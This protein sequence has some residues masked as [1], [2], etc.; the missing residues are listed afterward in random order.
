M[1]NILLNNISIVKKA[2]SEKLDITVSPEITETENRKRAYFHIRDYDLGNGAKVNITVIVTEKLMLIY[3]AFGINE[4]Q[5]SERLTEVLDLC[6]RRRSLVRYVIEDDHISIEACS[7]LFPHYEREAE[8]LGHLLEVYL[9]QLSDTLGE[10]AEAADPDTSEKK[11][12]APRSSEVPPS[13]FDF[14]LFDA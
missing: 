2:I 3:S 10:I 14:S 12:T 1:E 9:F 8:R 7:S 6:N 13:K 5:I 4:T 11:E